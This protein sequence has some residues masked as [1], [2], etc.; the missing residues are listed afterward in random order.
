MKRIMW[1]AVSLFILFQG[2]SQDKTDA[3][4][5]GDVK[6]L[7]TGEHIPYATLLLKDSHMGTMT[8]ASG[9]YKLPNLPAGRVVAIARAMGYRALEKE[10]VM[11]RGK[12]VN[13]FFELEEDILSLEQVVVTGTRSEHY[14][15]DVPVR[16]ERLH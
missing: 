13:L 3:M 15:K 12:A 1:I 10:V 6:S 9:H 8:D 7:K 5:F 16:R 11:E 14:I 4:L 2:F